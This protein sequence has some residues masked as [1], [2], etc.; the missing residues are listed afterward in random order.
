V[1][2]VLNAVEQPQVNPYPRWTWRWAWHWAK[3]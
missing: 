3:Q 2:M 1:L